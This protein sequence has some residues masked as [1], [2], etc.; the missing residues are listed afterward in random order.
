MRIALL[1]GGVIARLFLEHARAGSLGAVSV[2]AI[3]GRS[4]ASRARA[5]AG[6]AGIP[7]VVGADALAELSPDVVVGAASHKALR[8]HVETLLDRSISVVVMAGGAL[9]DEALAATLE[10]AAAAGGALLYVPSGGIGGL[11]ALKAACAAG[12]EEVTIA[13]T[14]PPAAWKGIAFV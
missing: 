1:G 5:L 14:K 8:D 2:T 7:F 12:A 9:P 4:A 3:A 10:R 13:V 11:D 6:S